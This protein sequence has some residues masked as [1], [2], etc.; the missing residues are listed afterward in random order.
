MRMQEKD[1]TVHS[2]KNCLRIDQTETAFNYKKHVI[3]DIKTHR[4]IKGPTNKG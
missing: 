2:N 1:T 3:S 4:E